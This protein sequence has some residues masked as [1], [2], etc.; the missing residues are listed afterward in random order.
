MN[1]VA[2]LLLGLVAFT[3]GCAI[4]HP[5][6]KDYDAHLVKYG[7]EKVL[8]MTDME[9][10][11]LLGPSTKG[12][13]YEFRAVSVGYAHVWIVEFGKILDKTLQA[14]YVQY[15]FEELDRGVRGR[16]DSGYVIEF[17]LTSFEFKNYR[18]HTALDITVRK[19]GDEVFEK[20]YRSE[21]RSQGAQMWT[22]GVFGMKNATLKSTKQSIDTI[23]EQFILD[24]RAREIGVD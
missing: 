12:H 5:V 4:S 3:S 13:S 17:D 1:R 11:Y 9:A 15:A 7:S 10:G 8:P 20:L 24:L 14:D 2:V 23:L 22:A 18:A 19:D 21:G 16:D 6:A